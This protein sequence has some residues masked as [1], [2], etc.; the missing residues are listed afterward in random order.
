MI[1]P[2][3]DQYPCWT[4]QKCSRDTFSQG[5]FMKKVAW[6]I[7]SYEQETQTP[8]IHI[9]S[10]SNKCCIIASCPLGL[11]LLYHL[12]SDRRKFLLR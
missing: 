1:P 10:R 6:I 12:K 7:C 8:N 3:M 2:P 4:C 11:S 9:A 5:R